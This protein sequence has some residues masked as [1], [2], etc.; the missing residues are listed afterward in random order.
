MLTRLE[1]QGFKNFVNA[2]LHL[3]P[4]TVLVGTNAS[5]KSNVRDAFRFLHGIG[6]GYNLADILGQ[7]WG[8]EGVPLW[9]GIRGGAREAAFY[10][11]NRFRLMV[12][13]SVERD[14]NPGRTYLFFY[15]IEVEFPQPDR[16]PR[17]VKESLEVGPRR[18]M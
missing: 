2:Q 17:V 3:G 10:G 15:A 13:L 18:E 5:G 9:R 1:L 14:E 4:F 7:K 16:P 6:R 12:K 8:E 11:T